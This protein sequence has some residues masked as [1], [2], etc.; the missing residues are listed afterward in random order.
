MKKP[1]SPG[2]P[3]RQAVSLTK[4]AIL[5]CAM[6]MIKSRG[7]EAASFRE[8]ARELDVTAMAITYHVGSRQQMLSDLVTQAFA[9]VAEAPSACSAQDRLRHL[10]LSYCRKSLENVSLVQCILS[11]PA[12]MSDDL[13]DLTDLVRRETQLINSGDEGDILLNLLVDYANGFVFA[14]AAAPVHAS[15]TL[16]DFARSLDWLLER[17]ELQAIP[18]Q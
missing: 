5:D 11:N 2:R 4:Q 3:K 1:K 15:L 8:L 6:D 16:A 13:K 7:V 12:L 10:L 18:R 14:A 9:G 17:T